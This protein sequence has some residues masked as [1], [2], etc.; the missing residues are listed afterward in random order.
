MRKPKPTTVRVLVVDDSP[1]FRDAISLTLGEDPGFEVV[2]FAGDGEEG[3]ARTLA[4]EPDVVVM[5]VQMPVMDG[6][7]AVRAIMARRP[8]PILL[9]TADPRGQSTEWVFEA[10]RA[11]ALEVLLKPSSFPF[12]DRAASQLRGH[13]R[14]LA[15]VRV[16]P[17]RGGE[18]VRPVTVAP[19]ERSRRREVVGIVAS[20]GGPPVL[21]DVVAGLPEDFPMGLL[22]VQHLAPG[23]A[24][25]LAS[26]LSSRSRLPVEV[27]VDGTLLRPGRVVV[28]PDDRHLEVDGDG[29]VRT[30]DG[31]DVDG[32]RPSG[33]RLL[34]SL[35]SAY[36]ARAVGVVLTGMGRDGVRGLTALRRTGA[37]TLAQDEATSP[38]YGMPRQALETGAAQRA[39]ARD[40][41][42]S[43][44]V[45]L[46]RGD[47]L[48]PDG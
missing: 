41:L 2:G 20:A 3:L 21:A 28:A 36:G 37:V 42:A 11:G 6:L 12:S 29:R 31:P 16:R 40:H 18:A 9:Y 30:V 19:R 38:V 39:V 35:A 4:L 17:G 13:V 24:A 32:H 25:H 47:D 8:T 7:E 15:G 48:H 43:L 45:R 14:A 10:L 44:L 5:D 26:W 46:S 22:V 27:A 34:Q 33:D 1:V 23:F